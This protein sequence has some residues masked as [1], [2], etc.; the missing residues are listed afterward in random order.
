[1]LRSDLVILCQTFDL[2]VKLN[3]IRFSTQ[4]HSV[5]WNVQCTRKQTPQK[6]C[7]SQTNQKKIEMEKKRARLHY[8]LLSE[9]RSE[10]N[11]ERIE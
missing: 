8:F 1:M 4:L 3:C 11:I 10:W 2:R 6:Y 7:I 9:W 5:Y